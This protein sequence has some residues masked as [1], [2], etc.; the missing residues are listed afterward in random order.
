MASWLGIVVAPAVMLTQLS[1]AYALV[2]WA[3]ASQHHHVLDAVSAVALAAT[4]AMTAAGWR[5]MRV[6]RTRQGTPL[7]AR[8][9]F[10][11]ELAVS[12]AAL[13]TL[14]VLAQ[15]ATRLAIP[16]CVA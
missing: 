5:G 10:L 12:V 3:C 11:A 16:P 15:W 6:A 13:S 7:G 1:L 4:L 2:P 14:S 8:Q 9:A